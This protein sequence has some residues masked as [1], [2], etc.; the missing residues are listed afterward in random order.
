MADVQHIVEEIVQVR[1]EA[2]AKLSSIGNEGA[3]ASKQITDGSKTASA[4]LA[5]T[6]K[7]AEASKKQLI[8]VGPA[9]SKALGIVGASASSAAAGIGAATAA[10]SGFETAMIGV[11]ASVASAFASGGPVGA[12][13]ALLSAGIG[14]LIGQS[15][16]ADESFEQLKGTITSAM[17]SAKTEASAAANELERLVA[18]RRSMEGGGDG[19]SA[20]REVAQKQALVKLEKELRDLQLTRNQAAYAYANAQ[21]EAVRK[22]R[23]V[24]ATAQ[25]FGRPIEGAGEAMEALSDSSASLESRFR[26]ALDVMQ[27]LG[28]DTG[29]YREKIEALGKANVT[30]AEKEQA[31]AD[32]KRVAQEQARIAYLEEQRVRE[33]NVT[34]LKQEL[35]LLNAADDRTRKRIEN[36]R[37]LVGLSTEEVALL[38]QI[39]KLKQDASD[40]AATRAER[41]RLEALRD[42]FDLRVEAL[43]LNSEQL[44]Q[45][46]ELREI[47]R[48]RKELGDEEAERLVAALEIQRTRIKEEEAAR[49]AEEAAAR[50]KAKFEAEQARTQAIQKQ[51]LE[52]ITVELGR[53]KAE[54]K[55]GEEGLKQYN[56]ELERRSLLEKGI[57]SELIDQL[58]AGRE[59]LEIAREQRAEA[60]KEADAKKKGADATK[61][62]QKASGGATKKYGKVFGA[63]FDGG[64]GSDLF[65]STFTRKE[66]PSSPWAKKPKDDGGGGGESP[67]I[68]E[69][70]EAV[71][72]G[73]EIAK[74]GE[75]ATAAAAAVTKELERTQEFVRAMG[76]ELTN[77]EKGADRLREAMK[78]SVDHL[79][80]IV[81]DGFQ[82]TN[83]MISDIK[84]R[85]TSLER[86]VA[87]SGAGGVAGR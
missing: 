45:A 23:E 10:A 18:I 43:T 38:A 66:G 9:G 27:K 64:L 52:S 13:V 42:Q 7:E 62:A 53:I 5:N 44:R 46:N 25:A 77:V 1:D 24:L 35:E 33:Q 67:A 82:R 50:E 28:Q 65:A 57:S 11:G 15:I 69:A 84:A 47:E 49:K 87:N 83:S 80:Q 40:D 37:A 22:A 12:G 41:D 21:S 78:E 56:N 75:E 81:A 71:A 39:Q 68:K 70:N 72:V 3:K 29:S 17:Q 26:L 55:G 76:K 32:A 59:A 34:K 8:E 30:I 4:G 14:V 73:E 6:A 36:E 20:G 16:K 58:Q 19:A 48:V 74:I 63:T 79:A 85:L 2:S 61:D 60:E 54:L 51:T 31:I 86:Q